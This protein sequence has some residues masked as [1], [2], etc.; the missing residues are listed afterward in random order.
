MVQIHRKN[1]YLLTKKFFKIVTFRALGVESPRGGPSKVYLPPRLQDWRAKGVSFLFV[2]SC[3]FECCFSV[4]SLPVCLLSVIYFRRRKLS[5]WYCLSYPHPSTHPPTTP[6]RPRF[7]TVDPTCVPCCCHILT[8]FFACFGGICFWMLVP[9]SNLCLHRIPSFWHH[10]FEHR[11]RI[12][13]VSIC[14][15]SR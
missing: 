14:T 11:F 3:I 9:F 1:V 5:V 7:P 13:V 8:L 6:P 12:D 10:L 4:F 15:M 2:F